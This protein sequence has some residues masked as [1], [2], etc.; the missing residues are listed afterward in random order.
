MASVAEVLAEHALAAREDQVARELRVLL[1]TVR[2]SSARSISAAEEAFLDEFGGVPEADGAQLADLDARSVA[3]AVLEVAEWLSRAQVARLL[4]IDPSRVSHRLR[5]GDLLA[6]AGA[7]GAR[8]FPDWQF[9]DGSVLP[10]LRE[11][12]AALPAGAH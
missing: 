5:Q 2:S 1:N 8:R 3:R 9:E 10:H 11:L 6:Y 4:A 12:S 7:R